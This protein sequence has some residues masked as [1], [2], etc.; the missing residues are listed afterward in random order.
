MEFNEQALRKLDTLPLPQQMF[1]I[2]QQSGMSVE[3]VNELLRT[4][5]GFDLVKFIRENQ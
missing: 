5:P 4:N 3:D 1:L 2:M